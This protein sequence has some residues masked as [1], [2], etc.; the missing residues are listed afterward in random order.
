MK[1]PCFS[2]FGAKTDCGTSE[3]SV[4]DES[5]HCLLSQHLVLIPVLSPGDQLRIV[6]F[7]LIRYE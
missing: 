2:L 1:F 6:A 3:A 4:S 5:Q 7:P